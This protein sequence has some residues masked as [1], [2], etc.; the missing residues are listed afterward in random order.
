MKCSICN[1]GIFKMWGISK[2]AFR[3]SLVLQPLE[4]CDT[5]ICE[6]CILDLTEIAEHIK[7]FNRERSEHAKRS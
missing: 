6:Q 7:Y 1:C 3:A 4:H 5:I 2:T